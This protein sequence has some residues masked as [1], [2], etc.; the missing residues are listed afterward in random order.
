MSSI[1]QHVR[2]Q[3]QQLK[4]KR[5]LGWV[6]ID[7]SHLPHSEING[8]GRIRDRSKSA[9]IFFPSSPTRYRFPKF[10]LYTRYNN[11]DTEFNN[12]LRSLFESLG[13]RFSYLNRYS[14]KFARTRSSGVQKSSNFP[15][16]SQ[17]NALAATTV[18]LAKRVS[19]L[20]SLLSPRIHAWWRYEQKGWQF[21][22]P[23][24]P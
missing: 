2:V 11:F 18:N 16:L 15:R 5:K 3:Q 6:G 10:V 9:D 17:R 22:L 1:L 7:T 21:F 20:S 8:T 4:R 14:R 13:N 12:S 24:K 23:F 19:L